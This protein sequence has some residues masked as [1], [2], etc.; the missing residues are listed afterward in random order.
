MT[1]RLLIFGQAIVF[2][3]AYVSNAQVP[4]TGRIH[5]DQIKSYSGASSLTKPASIVVYN[6]ATTPEELRLNRAVLSRA[7]TKVRG[8]AEAEKTKLAK[9]VADEFAQSLVKDLQ[10]SGIPVSRGVAPAV[11]GATEL[12]QGSEGDT[13]RMA[14]AVAKQIKKG[15]AAQGW[16]EGSE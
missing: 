4:G 15:L 6:F 1:K 16:T 9:K 7:R 5:V 10:K 11:S 2:L 8:G 3:G 12:N 14:K 13:D